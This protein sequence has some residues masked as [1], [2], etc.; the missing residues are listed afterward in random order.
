MDNRKIIQIIEKDDN[1]TNEI[2]GIKYFPFPVQ[3]RYFDNTIYIENESIA[4]IKP[5]QAANLMRHI[6]FTESQNTFVIY[7]N[8]D[9]GPVV[10]WH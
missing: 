3:M 1:E 9:G 4:D 6:A 10:K 2:L 8:G 7:R 5:L